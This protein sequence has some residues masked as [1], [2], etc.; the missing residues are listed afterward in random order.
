MNAYNQRVGLRLT[1]RMDLES[2]DGEQRATPPSS[3]LI[4]I[5]YIYICTH[6]HIGWKVG[7]VPRARLIIFRV[8]GAT[9]G[10]GQSRC[11]IITHGVWKRK[12][13]GKN[14]CPPAK[15]GSRFVI[16][17][18]IIFCTTA[19]EIRS[20]TTHPGSERSRQVSSAAIAKR[21]GGREGGRCCS[22]SLSPSPPPSSTAFI[23]SLSLD[24]LSC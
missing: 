18:W 6:T 20:P 1:D 4:D 3:S 21:E 11:A 9:G 17:A 22:P 8:F 2:K 16:A 10:S 12:E 24:N 19:R 13:S 7:F 5:L 23:D 15:T 14:G